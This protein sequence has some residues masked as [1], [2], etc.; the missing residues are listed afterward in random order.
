LSS[1]H[2]D[3]VRGRSIVRLPVAAL[4]ARAAAAT[5][6]VVDVGAG[7]G[8]FVYRLARAHRDWL[9]VAVDACAGGMRRL[10]RQ[11]E[12][13][14]SRGG[15]PNVLFVRAA[16]E[17]LPYGLAG[18]ADEVTVFY[19]WG[20]LLRAIVEP[21]PGVLGRIVRLGRPA[22]ALRIRV[23]P[24]A[25]GTGSSD[26]DHWLADAE[27]RLRRGYAE[28]GVTLDRCGRLA[29]AAETSWGARLQGGRPADVL[30]IEATL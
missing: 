21:D 15:A 5:R 4:Q 3:V 28:L 9:C 30:A 18:I 12:R 22:A 16:A 27:P 1:D 19:P 20:S 13:K 7:D 26:V 11:A 24:T 25:L 10:S 17:S 14:P 6:V 29:L 23:N 2:V 8:R